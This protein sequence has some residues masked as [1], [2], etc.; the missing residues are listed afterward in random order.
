MPVIVCL[1]LDFLS[2]YNDDDAPPTIGAFVLLSSVSR[3]VANVTELL[4]FA[5]VPIKMNSKKKKGTCEIVA[6][7]PNDDREWII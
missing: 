6:Q 7:C 2:L 1:G 3:M 5:G 4:S